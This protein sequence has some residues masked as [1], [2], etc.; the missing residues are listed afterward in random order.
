MDFKSRYDSLNKKIDK[1]KSCWIWTACKNKSG[2]GIVRISGKNHRA[3]RVFWIIHNGEI[4]PGFVVCH[5][6]DNPPCVN[7][8][9]LFVGTKSDNSL[10]MVLKFR[11]FSQK[12]SLNRTHCN[13]GKHEWISKNIKIRKSGNICGV[14]NHLNLESAKR[15]G[16][17]IRKL[18]RDKHRS[19]SSNKP[20]P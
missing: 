8:D 2:Y 7:P 16:K 19:K 9:H 18:K 13:S 11:S 10:D 12:R 4:P 6:C 20:A 1:T 15:D 3:H 5:K 17:R 14:C